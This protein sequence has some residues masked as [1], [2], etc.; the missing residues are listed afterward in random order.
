MEYVL[1]KSTR[2]GR[3]IIQL[4]TIGDEHT[5]LEGDFELVNIAGDTEEHLSGHIKEHYYHREDAEGKCYDFYECD[6]GEKISDLFSETADKLNND[7]DE[8]LLV[9]GGG[10][11]E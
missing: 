5:A 7:I 6:Y 9:I 2:G 8:L 11:N 10:V 4:K 3:D 1:G